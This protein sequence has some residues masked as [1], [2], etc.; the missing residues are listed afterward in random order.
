LSVDEL[1]RY[2]DEGVAYIGRWRRRCKVVCPPPSW[3]YRA[4][5]W[6]GMGASK[7]ITL[8]TTYAA[9]GATWLPIQWHL[10]HLHHYPCLS[11]KPV[12]WWE[13]GLP[14]TPQRV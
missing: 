1:V 9:A 10:G 12:G 2:N 13:A 7:G 3:S 6:G 8:D 11:R 14:T 5:W 4:C